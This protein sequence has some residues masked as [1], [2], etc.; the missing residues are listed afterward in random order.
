[1]PLRLNNDGK[2]SKKKKGVKLSQVN[3]VNVTHLVQSSE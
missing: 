1:M 3:D 2:R